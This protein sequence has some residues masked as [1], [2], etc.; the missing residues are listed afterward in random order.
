MKSFWQWYERHYT[1]N[2]AVAAGLFLLQIV[3]LHW[4]A[5]DVIIP[6]LGGTSLWPLAAAFDYIIIAVDYTEIPAIISV[7]L[8]YIN[9]LR[10]STRLRVKQ[11]VH[12]KPLLFLFLLNS[13]W[14]HIF[15]ITDEF[16]VNEFANDGHA[17]NHTVLPSW[18]AW[19]AILIDY[20]EVPV[21]IDTVVRLWREMRGRGVRTALSK[22]F[23]STAKGT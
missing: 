5:L 1:V 8:L 3:H 20:A 21:M 18:L 4:L 13:Q 11:G 12:W 6:R 23:G 19:V 16:V 15:W 7:S 17:H 22:T 2:V 10:P 14:L 9:D